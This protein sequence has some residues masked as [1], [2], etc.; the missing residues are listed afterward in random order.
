M[1]KELSHLHFLYRFKELPSAFAPGGTIGVVL[2]FGDAKAVFDSLHEAPLR[3]SRYSFAYDSLAGQA[4][5]VISTSFVP[6]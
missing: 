1:R 2:V 3:P 4:R 5:S 6:A